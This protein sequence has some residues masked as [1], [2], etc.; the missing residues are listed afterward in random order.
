M[1]AL[2]FQILEG[3]VRSL[4]HDTPG[5]IICIWYYIQFFALIWFLCYVIDVFNI[6]TV[7]YFSICAYFLTLW[8]YGVHFSG[9]VLIPGLC[10]GAAWGR[11]VGLAVFHFFPNTV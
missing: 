4:F 10:T 3:T 5:I 8:S 2:W 11:L 1:A 7:V 9:G 6:T